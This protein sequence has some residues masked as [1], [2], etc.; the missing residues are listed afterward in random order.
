VGRS[1]LSPEQAPEEKK[2]S[3][4]KDG[5]ENTFVV[6]RQP[7]GQEDVEVI[8]SIISVARG[9]TSQWATHTVDCQHDYFDRHEKTEPQ[10]CTQV[11]DRGNDRDHQY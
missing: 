11:A 10:A 4:H 8:G 2:L 1:I 5:S 7:R 9:E 6:P 3:G